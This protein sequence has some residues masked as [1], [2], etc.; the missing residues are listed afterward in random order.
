VDQA[1]AQA[2]A[3]EQLTA[4]AE[5]EKEASRLLE[6][7]AW[8]GRLRRLEAVDVH[9]DARVVHLDRGLGRVVSFDEDA[10]GMRVG[11]EFD[12]GGSIWLRLP[13]DRIRLAEA[14]LPGS[15]AD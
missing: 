5:G 13:N 12:G 6:R 10:G 4:A 15:P 3:L 14:D 11:I 2:Q 9:F 8:T 7:L 1:L